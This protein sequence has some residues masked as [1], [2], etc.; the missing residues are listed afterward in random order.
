MGELNVALN[1]LAEPYRSRVVAE[2]EMLRSDQDRLTEEIR[3]KVAEHERDMAAAHALL[4]SRKARIDA[5]EDSL[6]A[7]DQ[8]LA[9]SHARMIELVADRDR[10]AKTLEACRDR[11][12]PLED[13]RD[14]KN[15]HI[16]ELVGRIE[17][18]E[19]EVADRAQRR[20]AGEDGISD[21][22]WAGLKRSA[23]D[24]VLGALE[25][26]DCMAL[27]ERDEARARAAELGRAAEWLAREL[28]AYSQRAHGGCLLEY[29]IHKSALT[30]AEW[31]E[32]ALRAPQP[33][34]GPGGVRRD[35]G[36]VIGGPQRSGGTF[37]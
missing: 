3:A 16:M 6:A 4:E 22:E 24:A 26:M 13:L 32:F 31:I 12:G 28:E 37:K 9:E 30:A 29:K 34:D 27:K 23:E 8:T 10:L 17:K 11:V 35:A 33:Q 14:A 7:N 15:A 25:H 19:A 20:A 2:L 18:L 21:D 1:H 36:F 5:L